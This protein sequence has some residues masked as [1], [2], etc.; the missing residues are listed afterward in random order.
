MSLTPPKRLFH[1]PSMSTV[2]YKDVAN[3]VKEKGYVAISHVWGNQRPYT[4]DELG[5]E[6]GVD[7]KIPLSDPNK[8]RRLICAMLKYEMEY[9]WWDILCM[10]QDKQDE[11]NLEIPLMGDYYSGADMTF[12]LQNRECVTT[13]NYTKWCHMTSDAMKSNRDFTEDEQIWLLS[14]D[15]VLLDFSDEWFERLWTFQEAVLSK[16]IIFVRESYLDMLDVFTRLQYLRIR[17]IR[18]NNWFGKCGLENIHTISLTYKNASLVDLIRTSMSRKSHR[19]HD[20]FYGMF[21]ILGYKDFVVDYDIDMGDLN[22]KMARHAYSKGDISWI[23]VGGHGNLDFINY[24][25]EPFPYVGG[26][27]KKGKQMR[28]LDEYIVV[29][30]AEV[31]EITNR[32][33]LDLLIGW[34]DIR[35][36]AR[37]FNDWNVG[38]S[39]TSFAMLEYNAL[40]MSRI[41]VGANYLAAINAGLSD[42]TAHNFVM[43]AIPTQ[44]TRRNLWTFTNMFGTL[45][46]TYSTVA[47]MKSDV[48]NLGEKVP[49]LI[50]GGADIGDK[51]MLLRIEDTNGRYLGV[52]LDKETNARKGMCILPGLTHNNGIEFVAYEFGNT[53]C[54]FAL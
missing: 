19:K 27:W 42:Q 10:P 36:I 9:C 49:L 50:S 46:R 8:I 28:E 54:M 3:D 48:S 32:E 5:I 6:N 40:P 21:G 1:V 43:H 52:I 12:V 16:R 34:D 17:Q 29:K 25:H 31:G 20:K 24:M 45:L 2:F 47:I 44:D 13:D 41:T 35:P 30:A 39:A 33:E 11:I 14:R 37:I 53:E 23:A 38:Y 15:L 4:A 51:V 22:R 26:G 7:W 18:G